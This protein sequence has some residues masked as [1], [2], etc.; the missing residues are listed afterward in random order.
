MQK[1]LSGASL[2]TLSFGKS[3]W[4]LCPDGNLYLDGHKGTFT[5]PSL[6]Q[7]GLVFNLIETIELHWKGLVANGS[8]EIRP[9]RTCKEFWLL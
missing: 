9:R 4:L 8:C 6:L 2:G 1:V 5:S 7:E 3:E